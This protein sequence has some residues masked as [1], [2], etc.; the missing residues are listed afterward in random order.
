[1]YK[2]IMRLATIDSVANS[3]TLRTNLN[4]L[5]SYA[6]SVNGNVNLINSYFDTNYTQ[7]LAG[8]ATVDNPTIKLFDV[9]LSVPYYNFKQ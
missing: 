7:I 5:T 3:K 2:T 8:G 9:Y 1:M 4:N 6:T